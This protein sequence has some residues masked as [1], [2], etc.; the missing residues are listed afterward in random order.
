VS[1]T[2]DR[3]RGHTYSR[4][5]TL[6]VF[7]CTSDL[8]L[9]WTVHLITLRSRRCVASVTSPVALSRTRSELVPFHSSRC[10][11]LSCQELA[12]SNRWPSR[13]ADVE[14]RERAS[15][16][17]PPLQNML[18]ILLNLTAHPHTHT[19]PHTPHTAQQERNNDGGRRESPV[20]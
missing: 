15:F 20:G 4:C 9:V 2:T 11:D 10:D 12:L 7:E 8:T 13:P 14:E 3:L 19:H 6:L 18:R 16:H 1:C 5:T 17:P